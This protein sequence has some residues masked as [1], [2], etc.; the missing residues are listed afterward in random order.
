M[1]ALPAREIIPM[2]R[3]FDLN[4]HLEA[5]QLLLDAQTGDGAQVVIRDS[6]AKPLV[7]FDASALDAAL[8]ELVANARTALATGGRIIVRAK[9]AGR[10]LWVTVAD[11]GKGMSQQEG[12]LRCM[13]AVGGVEMRSVVSQQGATP[14]WIRNVVN[15]SPTLSSL[16]PRPRPPCLHS[17]GKRPCRMP[18]KSSQASL[19]SCRVCGRRNILPAP[20]SI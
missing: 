20:N 14:A 6:A 18:L 2:V 8:V 12:K 3:P 11:T 13:C 15:P 19:I 9:R 10:R 16:R 17:L 5:L 1:T 7:R 4:Q